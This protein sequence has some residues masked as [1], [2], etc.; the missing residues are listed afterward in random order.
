MTTVTAINNIDSGFTDTDTTPT[1]QSFRR[2]TAGLVVSAVFG[3]IFGLSGITLGVLTLG[4]LVPTTTSIYTIGTVLI[5][6]SFIL[7]GLGAHCLDKSEA[8]DEAR[9][10]EYCRSN[11]LKDDAR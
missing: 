4:A 10:L 2:W 6:T 3:G 1:Q 11:G 8:A 7:F 5:G 9:R